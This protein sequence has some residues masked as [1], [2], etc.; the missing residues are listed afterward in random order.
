MSLKAKIITRLWEVT[1]IS[2]KKTHIYQEISV[3]ETL[4][5]HMSR[6]E[7]SNDDSTLLFQLCERKN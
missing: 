4:V 5:M 1:E 3:T 6:R 7:K 2:E